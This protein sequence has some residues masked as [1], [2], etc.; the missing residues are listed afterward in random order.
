M[1]NN[2]IWKPKHKKLLTENKGSIQKKSQSTTAQTSKEIN[3]Y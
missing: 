1:D 3:Y 2:I